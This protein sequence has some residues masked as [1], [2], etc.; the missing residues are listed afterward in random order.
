MHLLMLLLESNIPAVGGAAGGG[1]AVL[2]FVTWFLRKHMTAKAARRKEYKAK[3]E[4]I[5]SN[6][7]QTA[8][9]IGVIKT[10]LDSG[11][12]RMQRI[13]AN[14]DDIRVD[15]RVVKRKATDKV[16]SRNR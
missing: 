13:E 3:L 9:D 8:V 2:G 7:H 6:T 5:C 4:Q 15:M 12:H 10:R 14:V 11:D 1:S 16:S